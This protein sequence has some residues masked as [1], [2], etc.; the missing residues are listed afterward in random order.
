MPDH[1]PDVYVGVRSR[2]PDVAQSQDALAQA[3]LAVAARHMRT[4]VESP[5]IA[6]AKGEAA[7][8]DV[9]HKHSPAV[10][11]RLIVQRLAELSSDA[12]AGSRRPQADNAWRQVKRRLPLIRR[13]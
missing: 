3:Y 12:A 1:L 6:A 8:R 4:V 10:A 13:R 11:A 7:A 5:S 9:A 2:F